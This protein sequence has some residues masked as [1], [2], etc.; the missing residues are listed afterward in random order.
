[1]SASPIKVEYVATEIWSETRRPV[2]R[3]YKVSNPAA[4]HDIQYVREY[5][6]QLERFSS[7]SLESN[8]DPGVQLAFLKDDDKATACD[9]ISTQLTGIRRVRP[10]NRST[11][12]ATNSTSYLAEQSAGD[13]G[14]LI[15]TIVVGFVVG[16]WLMFGNGGSDW[17]TKD[18]SIA[19]Y[20]MME[21]F[22][23]RRLK[24]PTSARFPG[25]SERQ[26]H[27]TALGN[28]KYRIESW[29]DAQ[30]A[31]GAQIRNRF[32]GEI[33][34]VDEDQWRLISLSLSPR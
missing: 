7:T 33:L 4:G 1:M 3:W 14:C 13:I 6:G 11:S 26:R 24:S 17:Q 23:T 20:I 31:F 21:D 25:I 27:V 32:V 8:L 12:G 16:G 22:V 29:V 2:A 10:K 28:G 5:H 9:E 19:A 18:D 15:L 34:Q 30:N